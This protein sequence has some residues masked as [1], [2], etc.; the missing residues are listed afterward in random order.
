MLVVGLRTSVA[1]TAIDVR[2]PPSPPRRSLCRMATGQLLRA[3]HYSGTKEAGPHSSAM[4]LTSSAMTLVPNLRS[5]SYSLFALQMCL[6][7]SPVLDP[8]DL[9][10]RKQY[11]FCKQI[12]KGE[13]HN[14]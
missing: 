13:A 12:W 7:P 14:K 8:E 6:T 11:L 5:V 9:G 4:C 3:D 10:S 1:V 2:V